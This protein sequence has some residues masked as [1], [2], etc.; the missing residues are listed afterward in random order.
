MGVILQD[1]RFRLG[2]AFAVLLAV[3]AVFGWQSVSRLHQLNA[4][5]QNAVYVR[6]AEEEQV[7]EAFRLS[8]LNNR[9]TLVVFLL[10]DREQIQQ[11]LAERA[12]NTQRITELVN[13]IKATLRTEKEKKL[14][15]AVETARKP[16]IESYLRALSLLLTEHKP[17]EARQAMIK[18]TLPLL[19]TYHDAWLA[20]VRLQ[21]SEI[22]Q[23]VQQSKTS[24]VETER[25][26][27]F[28]TIFAGL[29]T[30]VIVIIVFTQISRDVAALQ[31]ER[32]SLERRVQARTS[33]L[34]EASKKAQ[35]SE[36]RYR[37]LFEGS[38]D[39]IMTLDANYFLDCNEA[40]LK[41]FGY[42]SKKEF[43]ALHPA[44][45]SPPKQPSGQD[46]KAAVDQHIAEALT[47]GTASFEWV[48]RRHNGENFPAEFLLTALE[49]DGQKILQA[50]VR[51]ISDR[52]KAQ[53]ALADS[54]TQYRR[55]FEAAKDGILILNA[56]TGEI[57]DANPFMTE[58]LGYTH[59][60]FVGKRL[61]ELGFFKDSVASQERLLKLQQ[62][63]YVRY[64]DLPLQ[65]ADGKHIE[66]E[67]V[68]NVYAV[69]SK[70]VIQCNIRDITE[71]KR[72]EDQNLRLVAIVQSADDAIV[73]KT[74]DGIITSWNKGAERT[75]GY[76][77][78]EVVGKPISILVPP[79]H[80]DE[81]ATI[82][83]KIR[84]GEHIE[85]YE[86][87]RRRKD[88]SSIDVSLSISPMHD[89]Q[90][91]IIGIST[92]ARDI[93]ERKTKEE[94]I[95]SL[96][97]QQR[98]ILDASPAMV[99]YKDKENRFVRVNEA[100]AKISGLSKE[101]MEGK[102]MWDL[103]PKEA[104][105][106]YW[107]KD[108]EVMASGKPALNIIEELKTSQG[109]L[110]VQTDKI[111]YRNSKG[112][113][114]GIIGFSVDITAR[115]ELEQELRQSQK[116]E[117]IGRL[118]GGV[119]HDFNNILTS[120]IGYGERT[121]KLLGPDEPLRENIKQITDGAQR[122]AVLTR[123]LL[124]FGRKQVL[125]PMV[126]DMN[127]VITGM[128][129]MLQGLVSED[130]EIKTVLAHRLGHTRADRGQIE[131]VLLN[132]VM[133][134][135]DAMSGKGRLT[136]ET[137]N[138]EFDAEY[139]RQNPDVT[140]GPYVMF[141]VTDTGSGMTDAV[142]EHLFE[143][144]FTTKEAGKGTG[145][146]L[147]T[148]FGIIKQSR[149][150]ISIQSEPDRGTTV[151]V[152]LPRV[153]APVVAKHEQA[154]G[155]PPRGKE[156]ILLVEDEPVLRELAQMI[157]G[158]LGYTVLEAEDG[159]AALK[160]IQKKKRLKLDLL[161]SDIM[162]PRM[163]GMELAA[164]L[165]AEYPR[166]KILLMSGYSTEVIARQGVFEPGTMFIAKPFT[167]S[168]LARK[169]REALDS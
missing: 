135:R 165:R 130:I 96:I 58:L 52:Q 55:L 81:L 12:A 83:E 101:E 72:M 40:T 10:D 121:L 80:E 102:T 100:F 82:L 63:R 92:V 73:G 2:A 17:D 169:V 137:A 133:N 161:L 53:K 147:A 74:L 107:Q 11:L 140:P 105:E 144:F 110:W 86:T 148:C 76:M 93:T 41:M 160:L 111:P 65:T 15:A 125:Q 95:S 164:K 163:G 46:S 30:V 103:Y 22:D 141:A 109:V 78:N 119:A 47:K 69:D 91:K 34:E 128:A 21:A 85:H 136:I 36:A 168:V 142:K 166:I 97:E 132:L 71:R 7:L 139:V 26:F 13:T 90:G 159:E 27:L 77:E 29:V 45:V 24:F 3:L 61:W 112:E 167:P 4:Q 156:T 84:L 157:L 146:G 19:N 113:I 108:K 14:L 134:A 131:Q 115:L 39:A 151:R 67:F 89:A 99:F 127:A 35:A 94:Q 117:A 88:G 62:E 162:M 49:V 123:Q 129:Q 37:T 5:I 143:P 60:Q 150:Y 152:H 138:V 154:T 87:A 54:E 9:I 8:N 126:L 122:A 6:W 104:A 116:M 16:Y 68:S 75:Y 51:D 59:E 20:F 23:A 33:E 124:A 28:L 70:K 114:V 118:A 38:S 66:V 57:E 1:V 43:I 18:V 120:I 79:G 98:I 32:D 64:E 48:H 50:T 149:G 31:H 25:R 155:E 158:D 145:M 42:A 56:E 153:E 44:D 106:H